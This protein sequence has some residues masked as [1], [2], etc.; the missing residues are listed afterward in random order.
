MKGGQPALLFYTTRHEWEAQGVHN[1]LF[2][3]RVAAIRKFSAEA[4][5]GMDTAKGL[6]ELV[7]AL[8]GMG[9][10]AL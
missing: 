9:K 10:H 7:A 4:C 6:T 5:P 2:R 8:R 3:G 1:A